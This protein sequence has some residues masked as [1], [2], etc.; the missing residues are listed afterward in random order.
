M[1]KLIGITGRSGSGK[2]AACR[3]FAQMGIPTIDTDAI[4]HEILT[5]KGPC[6]DELVSAFGREILDEGGLVDRRRLS[7]AVFGQKNTPSLLHTLNT[8]THKYIMAEAYAQLRELSRGGAKAVLLDAPQLF[9]AHLE[10]ECDITLAVIADD[11]RCIARIMA[12]DGITRERASVRLA[13]Q[14]TNDFFR[15]HCTA[16]I[17][18]NADLAALT[19]SVCQFIKDFKVG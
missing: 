10:N 4:Y 12:R 6:T 9:E 14:H 11:E 19:L 7:G 2:G 8:I 13:A 18:N 1:T 5:K 3:I 16:V 17:E 15:E